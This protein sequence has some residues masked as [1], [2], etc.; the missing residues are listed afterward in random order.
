MLSIYERIA[1][2]SGKLFQEAIEI[3]RTLHKWPEEGFKEFKTSALVADYLRKLG[4]DEV[5]TE[6]AVTGVIGV[7]KGA[8]PGPTIAIRADMDGLPILEKTG[9]AFASEREGWMHGC[10]H[11]GHTAGLLAAAKLLAG[12]RSELPGTVKF[13]FQPAEEGPGGALPMTEQGA[14][15]GVDIVLGGHMWGDYK[16]GSGGPCQRADVR[17]PF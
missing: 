16:P 2:E 9:L 13:I 6:V 10:G 3:R 8:L 12:L 14:M 7:L 15:D 5:R 4:L 1:Q 17:I 11:D